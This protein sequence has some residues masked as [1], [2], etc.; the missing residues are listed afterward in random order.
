MRE[1]Q[2][3]M[4]PPRHRVGEWLRC[5]WHPREA[6]DQGPRRCD[7]VGVWLL[8]VAGVIFASSCAVTP[9]GESPSQSLAT[10]FPS[11][12]PAT[13][14]P[15]ASITSAPTSTLAPSPEGFALRTFPVRPQSGC[16]AMGVEEPVHGVLAGDVTMTEEPLWLED[17][18]GR[19]LSIVWPEG[20]T[21]R[22]YPE[23]QLV[24]ET[25]RV[26]AGAGYDI[27]LQV[28]S[29]AAH[30]TFADPYIAS[31]ILLAG[32]SINPDNFQGATYNE[33]YLERF[34]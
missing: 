5:A 2:A 8:V 34:S 27:W 14:A 7:L 10:Q 4:P 19:R 12:S 30:G 3:A 21:A 25:G 11:T 29:A 22:F 28:P 13:V 20:F 9:A 23:V 31:G 24:D 33:C 6:G 1:R 16:D 18:A 15:S 17:P 32:P 26:V